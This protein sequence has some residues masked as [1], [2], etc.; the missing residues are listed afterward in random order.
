LGFQRDEKVT[1]SVEDTTKYLVGI[2][3]Y[4]VIIANRWRKKNGLPLLTLGDLPTTAPLREA[5]GSVYPAPPTPP[6]STAN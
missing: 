3:M 1:I 5:F 2:F 6:A 4:G